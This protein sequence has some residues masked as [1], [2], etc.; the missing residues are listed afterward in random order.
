MLSAW[1]FLK[2]RAEHDELRDIEIVRTHD[3]FASAQAGVRCAEMV[4]KINHYL[5]TIRFREAS[6][7]KL[8]NQVMMCTAWQNRWDLWQ[9]VC[10]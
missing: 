4:V 2:T 5:A 8:E 10:R 3:S 7:T 1:C 6:L 9:A